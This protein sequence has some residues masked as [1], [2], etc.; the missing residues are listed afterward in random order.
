MRPAFKYYGGKFV[1]APWIISFFPPHRVYVEPCCGAASVLLTKEPSEVETINDLNSDIVNFF[2]VLRD[3]TEALERALQL[4]PWSREEYYS[5]YERTEDP[6]ENARRFWTGCAMSISNLPYTS[7]GIN[8]TGKTIPYKAACRVYSD[9]SYLYAVARRFKQVQ[10]ENDDAISVI[11]RYDAPHTLIYFDPPYVHEKRSSS[12][13]SVD[14]DTEFHKS[15]AVA[16]RDCESHVI[17]SGYECSLYNELYAGW[18]VEKRE[19]FANKGSRKTEVLWISPRAW[20]AIK[21]RQKNMF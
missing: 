10:I 6:V 8:F 11:K 1:L 4:T 21:S 5:H 13:Y 12:R 9:M 16:L 7:S 15:A 17:V 20:Q 2:K 3:N 14:A 19:T 18:H